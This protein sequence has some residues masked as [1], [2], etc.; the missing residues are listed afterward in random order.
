M[1]KV[2]FPRPGDANV[3]PMQFMS[4]ASKPL[5]V[6]D[7]QGQE[8]QSTDF[9]T[10]DDN[11]TIKSQV[12][13]SLKTNTDENAVGPYSLEWTVPTQERSYDVPFEFRDVPMP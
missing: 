13:F 5:R 10:S 2:T 12:N 8:L 9:N 1:L 7:A 11:G 4:G 3:W 6:R